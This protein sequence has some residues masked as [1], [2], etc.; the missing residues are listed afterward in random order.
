MGAW[1]R[2]GPVTVTAKTRRAS[3]HPGPSLGGSA[4]VRRGTWAL[5]WSPPF[6]GHLSGL[7]PDDTTRG[8][9]ELLSGQGCRLFS[10]SLPP[11]PRHCVLGSCWGRRVGQPTPEK[12]SPWPGSPPGLRALKSSPG[13]AQ[14]PSAPSGGVED[15]GG[16][17]PPWSFCLCGSGWGLRTC[18]LGEP[19]LRCLTGPQ[20]KGDECR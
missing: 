8:E 9:L 14:V 12:L 10:A 15:A 5:L 19:A 2:A 1:P 18:L 3:R 13:G 17:G 4:A 7:G 11:P 6:R 20:G 16:W